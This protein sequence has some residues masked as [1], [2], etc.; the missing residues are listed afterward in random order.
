MSGIGQEAAVHR[1]AYWVLTLIRGGYSSDRS[2][3]ALVDR[4]Q[5][6][7]QATRR[8]ERTDECEIGIGQLD[9]GI[10]AGAR[11]GSDPDRP[12]RE[13]ERRGPLPVACYCKDLRKV[14]GKPQKVEH[15]E[16]QRNRIDA[17]EGHGRLSPLRL[18]ARAR[19]ARARGRTGWACLRVCCIWSGGTAHDV[20]GKHAEHH[21]QDQKQAGCLAG[22]GCGGRRYLSAHHGASS[23]TD[24]GPYSTVMPMARMTSPSLAYSA[25][26]RAANTSGVSPPGSAPEDSNQSRASAVARILA[27]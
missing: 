14:G 25:R 7:G 20:L 15:V 24:G 22:T 26:T 21:D 6:H 13:R 2:Q 27:I 9:P 11:V 5:Q 4:E 3:R 8:I 1:H 16:G 12:E 10:E 19:R 18:S 23:T 17:V